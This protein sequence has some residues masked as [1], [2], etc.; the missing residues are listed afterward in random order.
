MKVR[1]CIIPIAGRG[2]RFLPVTK[3]VSKEM[4]PI[5]NEPTIL[6]LVKEC[7]KSG[8]EEIIFVVGNHNRH[9]VESFFSENSS[10]MEFLG[11]D[12]KKDLL[13]DVEEIRKNI[14]F[15]YVYQDENYRGTA[16]AIYAAKDYIQNEPFGVMYGDDLID[17]E[18]PVLKQV[19]EEYEKH[20]CNVIGVGEVP[21]ENVSNYGIVKYKYDNVVDVFVE[22]PKNEEAPSNHAL[23]GRFVL[24]S[25]VFD[26]ILTAEK[27]KNNEYFLPEILANMDE[28]LRAK[29]YNGTY[30]DIGSHAGYVKANIAYGLKDDKAREDIFDF[31]K[32]IGD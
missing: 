32:K 5:V 8:I 24:K 25:S 15:H 6:L 28:E 7:F 30:Y 4:L 26:H 22:K 23:H 20:D 1:K 17:A 19:I 29:K 10:L 11:N 3:T 21:V 2:T 14:K 16:G 12:P 27:H 9:L 31:I 13:N 18:V